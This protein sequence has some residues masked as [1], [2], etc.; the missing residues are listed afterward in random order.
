MS[1]SEK[2]KL[3]IAENVRKH[4]NAKGIS[5]E[6][7]KELSG[8]SF[9]KII[10]IETGNLENVAI[11]DIEAIAEALDVTIDDIIKVDEYK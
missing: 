4:R 10:N 5:H 6:E 3:M 2:L 9:G 1:K 8:L 11:E 7:L